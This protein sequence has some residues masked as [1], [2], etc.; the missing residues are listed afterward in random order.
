MNPVSPILTI[1]I[2]TYNRAAK[3]QAQLERLLPQLTPEVRLCVY[4]NASP[5]ETR[6]VVAKFPGVAYFRAAT[7]CGAGR[8]FFRCLEEC[9]TEWLWMLSDDD[10]ALPTAVAGLLAVLD[11]QQCDFI[12]ASCDGSSFKSE[13]VVNDVT[14]FFKHAQFSNALWISSGVYRLAAFRP[15]FRIYN[16]SLSTWGPQMVMVLALLESGR[17]KVLLSPLMLAQPNHSPPT[18]STL[19]CVLR[20]SLS[21]EYLQQPTHQQ[22]LAEQIF[23]HWFEGS[24]FYGLRETGSPAE[25]QRW[26]RIL[27]QVKGNLRAYQAR[28][29]WSYIGRNW[30][31]AGRRK[32]SLKMAIESSILALLHACPARFF[33]ALAKILPLPGIISNSYDARRKFTSS[34]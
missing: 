12:V 14:T 24:F 20:M 7:N 2:P 30:F 4:D 27:R 18:W 25:I 28:G 26:K 3:L 19:D 23:E 17:G 8:N 6:T 22:L 16:E 31:R 34:E 13:V 5:D 10:T 21:P 1:A 29:T 9:Q 11:N 15:L 32:R 33:H